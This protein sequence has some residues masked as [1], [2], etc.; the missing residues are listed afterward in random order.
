MFLKRSSVQPSSF[1]DLVIA[2]VPARFDVVLASVATHILVRNVFLSVPRAEHMAH[3]HLVFS[4]CMPAMGSRPMIPSGR[5]RL[6]VIRDLPA[7]GAI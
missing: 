6:I 4:R 3:T 7:W 5:L 2:S 1:Q